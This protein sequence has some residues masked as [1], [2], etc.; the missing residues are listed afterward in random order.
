MELRRRAVV[1]GGVGGLALAGAGGWWWATRRP[2]LDEPLTDA[3]RPWD[4]SGQEPADVR[5]DMLRHALLAPNAGNKQ[6]WRA[7][8]DGDD[9]VLLFADL[10]RRM[11]ATDP[12]DRRMT[13]SLG[14][15]ID[16]AV[17]AAS[18]RGRRVAVEG[19]PDGAPDLRLDARPVARLRIEHDGVAPE[20]LSALIPFRRTA[21]DAYATRM[22]PA[23]AAELPAFER[24]GEATAAVLSEAA[25]VNAVADLA[26]RAWAAERALPGATAEPLTPEPPAATPAWLV[27]ATPADTPPAR[28][29]AGRAY[30]RLALEAVAR[31]FD[32]EPVNAPLN[33]A[34]PAV[35]AEALALLG[36]GAPQML[37]RLGRGGR[38]PRAP[39]RPLAA[40]LA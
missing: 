1:A 15:F 29:M 14:A 2:P 12:D 5:L 3:T 24:R 18:R 16:Y 20:P 28:L 35:R 7:R 30:A 32:L 26:E 40:I 9:A 4:L 27:V 36:G 19:F 33:P 34:L 10:A 8:L 23:V 13:V 6:A 25:V 31:G 22:S 37:A 38:T 17:L 11:P 21:R 39:R